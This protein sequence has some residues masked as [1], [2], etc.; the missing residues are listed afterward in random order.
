MIDWNKP[1]ETKDGRK[2]RYLGQLTHPKWCRAVAI[3]DA[4][5]GEHLAS[6]TES[7]RYSPDGESQADLINPPP[8][9]RKEVLNGVYVLQRFPSVDAAK[10]CR[11]FG[12]GI[13]TTFNNHE[14]EVE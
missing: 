10:Y 5:T 3:Q 14:I 1:L 12:G 2:A 8:P 13:V 7:G 11:G 4:N 9:K 6:Y